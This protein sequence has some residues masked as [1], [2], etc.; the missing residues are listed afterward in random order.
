MENYYSRPH[1]FNVSTPA[2]KLIFPSPKRKIGRHDVY[3]S[4]P[5][6]PSTNLQSKLQSKPGN[7]ELSKSVYSTNPVSSSMPS[8]TN[9]IT[10]PQLFQSKPKSIPVIPT[11]PVDE[12]LDN[13]KL[14]QQIPNPNLQS[15]S[16]LPPQ[17]LIP[18]PNLSLHYLL[19]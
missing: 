10:L 8:S 17:I 4:I 14:L 7:D 16:F 19:M 18:Y 11:L 1:H 6:S 9:N 3:R 15:L 12:K 13:P 2:T 5:K